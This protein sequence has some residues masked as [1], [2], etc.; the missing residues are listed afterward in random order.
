[1]NK[2]IP[3]EVINLNLNL[4]KKNLGHSKVSSK[5]AIKI[6]MSIFRKLTRFLS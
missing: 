1:M 4:A 3:K 2:N 5:L 6:K